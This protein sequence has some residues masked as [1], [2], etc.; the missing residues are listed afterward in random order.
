MLQIY[1]HFYF[2]NCFLNVIYLFLVFSI[3][4]VVFGIEFKK[5]KMKPWFIVEID[6]YYMLY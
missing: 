4:L 1:H 6:N 2:L 3:C 5:I